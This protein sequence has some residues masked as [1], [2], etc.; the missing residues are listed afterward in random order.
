MRV[1]KEQTNEQHYHLNIREPDPHLSELRRNSEFS[2]T[3]P[4]CSDLEY[5]RKV[6]MQNSDNTK[7]LILWSLLDR[8][9]SASALILK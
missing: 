6:R 1:P 7:L 9:L 4:P 8:S 2:D 3:A 5:S